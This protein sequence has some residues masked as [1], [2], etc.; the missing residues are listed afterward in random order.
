[1]SALVEELPPGARTEGPLPRHQARARFSSSSRPAPD[2]RIRRAGQL[3]WRTRSDCNGTETA[4]HGALPR[5]HRSTTQELGHQIPS[6]CGTI[7]AYRVEAST[8]GHG[9]VARAQALRVGGKSPLRHHSKG[10]RPGGCASR[11]FEWSGRGTEVGRAFALRAG[12]KSRSDTFHRAFTLEIPQPA[13][14][15]P[16]AAVSGSGVG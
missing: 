11:N 6:A 14:G 13:A 3:E 1:V 2:R 10:V 9:N 5:R 15:L 12:T 8:H 7:D 4:A 16:L